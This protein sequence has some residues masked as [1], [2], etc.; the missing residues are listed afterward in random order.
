MPA[1]VTTVSKGSAEPVV[2]VAEEEAERLAAS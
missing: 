1:A 2:M